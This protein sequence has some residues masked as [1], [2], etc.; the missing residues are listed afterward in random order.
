MTFPP[1]FSTSCYLGPARPAPPMLVGARHAVPVFRSAP[2]PTVNS[3][4][5]YATVT[6]YPGGPPEGAQRPGVSCKGAIHCVP[7]APASNTTLSN[8]GL[9]HARRVCSHS[10]PNPFIRNGYKNTGVVSES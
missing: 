6:K 1:R 9:P 5:L 2:T 8:K 10:K 7:F 3:T 4:P